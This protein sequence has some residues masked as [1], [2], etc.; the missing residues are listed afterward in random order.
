MA[1]ENNVSAEELKALGKELKK[2]NKAAN[3]ELVKRSSRTL[4]VAEKV[5][6]DIKESTTK[7]I[8]GIGDKA[9]KTITSMP[10]VAM[11]NLD[12]STAMLLGKVG[13]VT[14][15]SFGYVKDLGKSIK[16]KEKEAAENQKESNE[17]L[18]Q[19][20]E[21]RDDTLSSVKESV[22]GGFGRLLAFLQGQSL[23]DYEKQ[24]EE[25]ARQK[26]LLAATKER[27]GVDGDGSEDES[28][29]GLPPFLVT[30]LGKI[31]GLLITALK[32][33][34][35]GI[36]VIVGL[37]TAYGK[38]LKAI[39]NVISSTGKLFA[40]AFSL[41]SMSGAFTNVVKIFQGIRE[42]FT[43]LSK[44]ISGMWKAFAGIMKGTGAIA[45][46]L[47]PL[48][49]IVSTVSRI[50]GQIF[51]PLRF[52]MIGFETIKGVLDGFKEEGIIGGIK[53]AI[54]G[55]F[56]GLIGIP[57][58]LI[59]N[60]LA[61]VLNKFGFS[62]VASA[63]KEFSWSD[64]I[65][66][67]VSIP[68]DAAAGAIDWVKEKFKG[69]GSAVETIGPKI[70]DAIKGFFSG[71][72]EGVK[73]FISSAKEWVKN[74]LGFKDGEMPS[75]LD[76]ITG[77]ITAPYDLVRSVAAWVAGKF[78][79]DQVSDFLSEFSFADLLLSIVTAPF[80]LLENVR[81]WIADKVS[82]LGAI[83]SRLIP[84]P[85]KRL[86]GINGDTESEE[87]D[88]DTVAKELPQRVKEVAEVSRELLSGAAESIGETASNVRDSIGG[89]VGGLF[90]GGGD[91]SQ[92]ETQTPDSGIEAARMTQTSDE[93]GDLQAQ[94]DQLEME[95][96]RGGSGGGSNVY[97]PTTVSTSSTQVV[98]RLPQVAS[99]PPSAH[100]LIYGG[101]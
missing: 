34:A 17:K 2:Q 44:N 14:K 99:R 50:V 3:E 75:I 42:F 72:G 73:N 5:S 101:A 97:A 38:E 20:I 24:R 89:F 7:G 18:E 41:K 65:K 51:V 30:S 56:N 70:G 10:D 91:E 53:G 93:F 13:D 95:Q 76:I 57:A 67:I 66:K 15:S 22:D 29:G 35:V 87:T 69:L 83:V 85:L 52:I 8:K 84:G 62:N 36:G 78:G 23:E 28:S 55:F 1:T 19:T 46:F 4:I 92:E 39:V 61:W 31:S 40:K 45:K 64:L 60:A 68:F 16:E 49:Q 100:D 11:A 80:K 25:A 37:I 82:G 74:Q 33:F 12:P 71:I 88:E 59:T 96:S 32:P 6:Q 58:D 21:D 94:R 27:S 43:T 47:S 54:V 98:K 63:L 26:Q 79:F 81:D 77:I 86:L 90:G 9:K 48:T